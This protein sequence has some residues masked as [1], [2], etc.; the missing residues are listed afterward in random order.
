MRRIGLAILA[1]AAAC[2]G[3]DGGDDD[4]GGVDLTMPVN[5]VLE[6]PAPQRLSEWNLFAWDA[7]SAGTCSEEPV[8]FHCE[9]GG[10]ASPLARAAEEDR[11]SADNRA[12]R[13]SLAAGDGL[14]NWVITWVFRVDCR[15]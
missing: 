4:G 6:G 15:G 3:D 9:R 12:N 7:A 13:D 2:G 14:G 1:A 11:N 8:A 10:R 5:V